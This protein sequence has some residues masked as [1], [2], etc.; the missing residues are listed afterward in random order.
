VP[1]SEV[2]IL[3]TWHVSGLKGTGSHDIQATD[4]FVADEWT[5]SFAEPA[6]VVRH[7]LDAVRPLGRLGL[8]LAAVALG[9]AQGAID[10]LIEIGRAKKPLGGLMKR[11]AENP[12]FQHRLGELDLELRTARIL[13]YNVARSDYERVT[14][15]TELGQ[16]ELLERRTVLVRVG[17]LATAVVDGC[18]HK[19]GTTGLFESSALQRRLRDIHAVVQHIMFTADVLTPSGALLLGEP[20]DGPLV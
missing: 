8:E 18:Y 19:S 2:E 11:M 14:A 6:P 7:P 15:G 1:A 10:D 17:E 16:R 4:L 12:A 9:T 20:V 3:D 13:L 5:G